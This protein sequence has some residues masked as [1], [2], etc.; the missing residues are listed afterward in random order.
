MFS[1]FQIRLDPL[2]ENGVWLP[3]HFKKMGTHCCAPINGDDCLVQEWT[4]LVHKKKVP[5]S[6][7]VFTIRFYTL[8][9]IGW[10]KIPC[11][12]CSIHNKA[13]F[14]RDYALEELPFR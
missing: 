10:I 11:I 7:G 14:P 3:I 2:L 12:K 6:I 9:R 8:L 13:S 5:L 4:I 1:V